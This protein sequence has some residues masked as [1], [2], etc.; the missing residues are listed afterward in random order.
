MKTYDRKDEFLTM[1]D[2]F[3]DIFSLGDDIGTCL[4][5]KVHLKLK[6]ESPF[7]VQPYPP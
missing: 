2:D 5:I 7:F 4:F 1:G 3:H 6:D